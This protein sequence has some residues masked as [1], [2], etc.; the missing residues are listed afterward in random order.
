MAFHMAPKMF[1][2]LSA[3]YD[4]NIFFLDINHYTGYKRNGLETI[5]QAEL[6]YTLS[7]NVLIGANSE[8]EVTSIQTLPIL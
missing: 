4:D 2:S 5:S 8:I 7:I 3:Y 6:S 1:L